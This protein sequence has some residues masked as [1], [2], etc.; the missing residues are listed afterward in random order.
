MGLLRTEGFDRLLTT[1]ADEAAQAGSAADALRHLATI[2]GRL[3][4][5]VAFA[6][7]RTAERRVLD[8]AEAERAVADSGA[9][10]DTGAYRIGYLPEGKACVL[11]PGEDPG[12]VRAVAG[13]KWPAG[14]TDGLD[15]YWSILEARDLAETETCRAWLAEREDTAA[16]LVARLRYL[17]QHVGP[18][19]LYIGNTCYTNLGRE[20]NL[21]GKS[22]APDSDRCRLKTLAATPARDW[23]ASDATFVV[24]M[25]AL[26]G[27]GTPSRTE[28]FSGT[29][30]LPRRLRHF[31]EDRIRAYGGE[32]ADEA[33]TVDALFA[34]AATAKR[35]RAERLAD[36]MPFYRT[37]QSMTI[38]KHEHVFERPV[39]GADLPEGFTTAV[40]AIIPEAAERLPGHAGLDF[41]LDWSP[42]LGSRPPLEA[43]Y[44][45]RFEEV[46][47]GLVAA[48]AEST[49]TDVAMSRGPRETLRLSALLAEG[50]PEPG[51]WKTGEY[52]CCVAPSAGFVEHLHDAGAGAEVAQAV[53]AIA[54]RMRWN[55]WHFMPAS[56]GVEDDPGLA[57]R[58][59]FFAP[60]MPDMT[61]WTSHHHQGHVA[62]GVRHA[63]RV[64][65]GITLA[66]AFRPGIHDLRL[67][68]SRGEVYAIAD[69]RAAIAMGAVFQNLYQRHAVH[70]ESTG[71][72]FTVRDFGNPWYQERY[73]TAATDGGNGPTAEANGGSR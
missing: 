50:S 5:E 11:R 34:L 37:V 62:N 14:A 59:W 63:I 12:P 72:P 61:E 6:A 2:G 20:G 26:I 41:D 3:A 64:P 1:V 58:D 48:A 25:S 35:L 36:G 15:A 32:P 60:S 30:L 16:E 31:I 7:L 51:H 71:T 29:Q 39:G 56:A 38:N 54:A 47:H 21:V 57:D 66:G 19:R 46:L 22:I 49:G 10:E 70:L 53:R 44:G 52:Y 67:M 4:P 33:A 13:I 68:R 43:G 55:C 9:A 28:E 8:I 23:D 69:L 73:G 65:F 18:I 40:A 24:G 45:S 42:V 27:S 17:F